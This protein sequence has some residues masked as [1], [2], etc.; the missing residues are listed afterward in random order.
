MS[1]EKK[2]EKRNL[3]DGYNIHLNRVCGGYMGG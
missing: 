2:K 1:K 3:S